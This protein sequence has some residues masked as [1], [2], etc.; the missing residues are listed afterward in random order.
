[1]F[2]RLKLFKKQQKT[3]I[4]QT[5]CVAR[6]HC[7]VVSMYTNIQ[8]TTQYIKNVKEEKEPEV[9]SSKGSKVLKKKNLTV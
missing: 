8:K 9:K 7:S 6:E 5:C 1:M 4:T 2:E 3:S